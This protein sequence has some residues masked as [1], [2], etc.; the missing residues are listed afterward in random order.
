MFDWDKDHD[1]LLAAPDGGE[2]VEA[3]HAWKRLWPWV[4]VA[5]ILI[6]FAYEKDA[7]GANRHAA[8][9]AFALP[10]PPSMAPNMLPQSLLAYDDD[11]ANTFLRGVRGMNG[12]A[13][14]AYIAQTDDD[15]AHADPALVPFFHDARTLLAAELNRRAA[16]APVMQ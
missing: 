1:S 15:M 5:T 4:L 2:P 10:Q 8:G 6:A 16:H 3:E 11:Q 12:A 7:L 14:R 13:L 9:L